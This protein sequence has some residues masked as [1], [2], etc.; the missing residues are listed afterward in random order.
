MTPFSII[1]STLAIHL[2]QV[3]FCSSLT[4]C[5]QHPFLVL[6]THLP[7]AS[8]FFFLSHIPKNSMA[9][10]FIYLSQLFELVKQFGPF[11][12]QKLS[13]KWGQL[14]AFPRR[15]RELSTSPCWWRLNSIENWTLYQVISGKTPF[16]P[17]IVCHKFQICQ[18]T[19]FPIANTEM[20]QI[21]W[22]QVG[23]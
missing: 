22:P 18:I 9:R 8:D 21:L 4:H 6:W 10:H 7:W 19:S 14:D 11:S 17:K 16:S 13:H 20:D 1:W 2:F 3:S 5:S 15:R 12:N 23:G